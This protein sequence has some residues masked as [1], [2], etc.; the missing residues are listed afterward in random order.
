LSFRNRLPVYMENARKSTHIN[1]IKEE[2]FI[3]KP[4]SI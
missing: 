4:S 3:K 1:R 2:D